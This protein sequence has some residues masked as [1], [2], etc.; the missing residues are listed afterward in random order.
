MLLCAR[1]CVCVCVLVGGGRGG[2][3]IEGKNLRSLSAIFFL[4]GRKIICTGNQNNFV[5]LPSLII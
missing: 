2:G 5:K 3:N 1:A 4:T